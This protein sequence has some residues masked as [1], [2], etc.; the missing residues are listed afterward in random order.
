MGEPPC[1]RAGAAGN[2]KGEANTAV[3]L[4]SSYAAVLLQ[5]HAVPE[6]GVWPCCRDAFSRFLRY[7]FSSAAASSAAAS[8]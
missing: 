1:G 5:V 6:G 2:R 4:L 8:S 7:I 3:W